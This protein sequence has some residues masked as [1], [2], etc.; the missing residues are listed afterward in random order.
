MTVEVSQTVAV[1]DTIERN[2]A[3]E[4]Q[5]VVKVYE[6]GRLR[7]DL[8]EY[9][10]TDQLAREYAKVLEHV[11]ESTRPGGPG[12][13]RVGI[14][15]S[16]FFGSG[17]SHFAKLLGHLLADTP[18]GTDT[19]RG[20]FRTL[21]HV[22]RAADDR[23][24]AGLQ[25]MSVSP[26]A[27]R[28][29]PF[30]ITALHSAAAER[31]VGLTLLRALYE[32]LGLSS[33]LVF[34]EVELELQAAG[35]YDAF[36]T[37][38]EEKSGGFWDEDKH[39]GSSNALI[40]ECLAET[41]PR[42]YATPERAQESL[43]F[44]MDDVDRNLSVD[45]VV[46]RLRR[47][48]DSESVGTPGVVSRL[49]FVAD[50]VGVWA[51]VSL[52]RIE[53]LRALIETLGARGES[54]IWL[55]ATSQ[56]KL[57]SVVSNAPTVDALKT[58]QLLERLE[59]RFKPNVHLESSEV[60]SVVEERILRKRPSARTE[61]DKLWTT[62]QSTLRD[63]AESPGLE[64]GATYPRAD[65]EPFERDYPFL[66]YQVLAAADIFGGMRGV[67]VSSGARSMI[68]VVF[69]AT[70][71][72]A[73]Q[74]LGAV[75]SW[76]AI[77][78]SA[79]RDNEF[80]DEQYLG[81]HGLS[82]I[83]EADR[84]IAEAP[85]RPSRLLKALWLV[86]QT[87]RIPRTPAN[88]ARLL[89]QNLPV[90]IFALEKNVATTLEKLAARDY[91]RQEPGTEQWKY[92]T[93]DE[94]TVERIVRRLGERIRQNQIRDAVVDFYK[95]GI[96]IA[97]NGQ[98]RVGKT[99]TLFRYGVFLEDTSL[100]A[101]ADAAV[102]LRVAFAGTPTAEQFKAKSANDLDAPVVYWIVA[103]AAKIRERLQ[104][105]LA[106]EQLE[107]DDE[108]K[109]VATAR[110]RA[111]AEKL[112][113]EA[114]LIRKDVGENVASV[115]EGGSLYYAGQ[116]EEI[117]IPPRS[118]RNARPTGPTAKTRLE[119]AL[120][121]RITAAYD[122]FADGDRVFDARN[123]ERLLIAA[124]GDR[125]KLD[126]SL[127]L[128]GPDGHVN[129]NNVLV[130]AI[131][132]YLKVAAKTAGEDV[133]A[134]FER[135]PY[136]WPSDLPRYVAAAMF[137]DGKLAI[138]DPGGRRHDDPKE[139]A[140]RALFGTNPFKKAKLELEEDALTPAESSA[141][142]KLLTDLNR[143]PDDGGEI[144]LKEATL[145]LHGDLTRRSAVV[146]AAKIAGFPLPEVYATISLTLEA[147]GAAGSR[148]KTI[149]VLLAKEKELREG[150]AAL[151]RLEAFQSSNG[152]A[153]YGRSG[154]LLAATLAA[155]LA[156][157]PLHGGAVQRAATEIAALKQQKRVLDEW[158]TSFNGYRV[159]IIE[160]FRAVYRPLREDLSRRVKVAS[161]AIKAMPE[162][163]R[164]SIG[165]RAQVR[166]EFLAIGK[167]LHEVTVPEL[168]SDAQLLA[169]NGEFTIAHLNSAL[170]A[171]DNQVSTARAR[172]IEV[173][174]R[175]QDPGKKKPA[176]V[177]WKASGALGGKTFVTEAD[178]DLAL[179]AA[180]VELKQIVRQGKTIQ[181][182]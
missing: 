100:S 111:E 150:D 165:G 123:V 116:S 69:D 57:S 96:P 171:L 43:R 121:S 104:R 118:G 61:L 125:A 135:I 63:I 24:R 79:N 98:L 74:P 101:S 44:A 9:V 144:A 175:E 147:I 27:F 172:V 54:R 113:E 152:F 162:Y 77:F 143:K 154:A 124:A 85:I 119:A 103:E 114:L 141:A 148:V 139:A 41:L 145:R 36:L 128:F 32:Q 130:E 19:T 107:S 87:R 75:V 39:L 21:L 65:R 110:T 23:V 140:A 13:D 155:G 168:K 11:V 7:T 181:V 142:R 53:Q 78:D 28:M 30:D 10:L 158:D 58:R 3:D 127:G 62:H 33:V 71:G 146:D 133:V 129:G 117:E 72:L 91:V 20:L 106:I 1:R 89:V 38:Y 25:A 151:T 70:R 95:K 29:V 120:K 26:L 138:L 12:T 59:A 4:P 8:N 167:P 164:L 68:R 35:V 88:L 34:A 67:K 137:V 6:I 102:S 48:L 81:S 126:A 52:D 45:S 14:W 76:D 136:G 40:A 108:Y 122:H 159:T 179:D 149:R 2:L 49:V 99:N 160:A 55:V 31:N 83:A 166:A 60:G 180:K 90:D 112:A 84:Q 170:A 15:V 109:H 56:E 153:Q 115:L 97:A 16:G 177:T 178:V 42:R 176:I 5:S 132:G 92:L 105:A 17:K 50:E 46:E 157:D 47:W 169:A 66:P 73:D 174:N 131:S 94:V 51:S 22:G 173:Y 134:N 93:Q 163:E 82:Y 156:D 161:D 37:L 80:A 64:L 182:V 86:Q 18:V